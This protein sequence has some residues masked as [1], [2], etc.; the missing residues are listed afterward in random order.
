[1]SVFRWRRSVGAALV[2]VA[3]FGLATPVAVAAPPSNDAIAAAQDIADI[4]SRF[5]ID[6]REA[7][8]EPFEP[9]L[10]YPCMGSRSIWYRFQPTSDI[11]ARVITVNSDYDN[12]V[13]VFTGVPGA[14]QLAACNDSIAVGAGVEVKFIRGVNYYIAVSSCCDTSSPFGGRAVLRLY[15]SAPLTATMTMTSATAGDISGTAVLSG[16]YRCSHIAF[17]GISAAVRQR[18]GS[19]VVRGPGS[20]GGLCSSKSRPWTMVVDAELA[21]AFRPGL[22]R[23][24]LSWA[25]T[26]GFSNT[27][28]RNSTRTV[29]LA[30]GPNLAPSRQ[31]LPRQVHPSP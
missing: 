14:I 3:A 7:T 16:N 11:V 31:A 1:M 6:T 18:I 10:G 15:G 20:S 26:D 8:T 28:L 25:A 29:Q 5:D 12:L 24:T 22:A 21:L 27:P 4:P 17:I 2:A 13:G 30:N 23:V 9:G 19:Q